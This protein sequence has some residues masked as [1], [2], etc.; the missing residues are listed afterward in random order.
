MKV[1]VYRIAAN[2][3]TFLP[4]ICDA[5]V[6]NAQFECVS[7]VLPEGVSDGWVV[8]GR[9]ECDIMTSDES[10]TGQRFISKR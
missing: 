7:A 1:A 6:P 9:T 5:E 4:R 10:Y 3:V 2:P 8:W